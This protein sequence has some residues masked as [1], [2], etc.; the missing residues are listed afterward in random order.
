MSKN[1]DSKSS[2][3]QS[4]VRSW[5]TVGTLTASVVGVANKA[6]KAK[7]GADR[8]AQAEVVVGVAGLLVAVAK[9][10]RDA[11][12]AKAKTEPDQT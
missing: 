12:K 10:F 2:D 4:A 5:M 7:G 3:R 11:R 9:T 8:I 1:S 6:R